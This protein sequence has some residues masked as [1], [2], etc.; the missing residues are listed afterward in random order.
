MY[1]GDSGGLQ[2][3]ALSE[4]WPQ[5]ARCGGSQLTMLFLGSIGLGLLSITT[6][7]TQ[8]YTQ[9]IAES[10]NFATFPCRLHRADDA[11]F[12]TGR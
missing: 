9:F 3:N 1:L 8:Q 10:C 5:T 2:P 7:Y 6:Y 12:K 4:W 11:K